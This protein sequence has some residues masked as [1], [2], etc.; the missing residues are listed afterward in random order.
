M[1]KELKV[2]ELF[3]GI[4]AQHKALTNIG[5]NALCTCCDIDKYAIQAYNAIHGET[6]NLGDISAI[7]P[8]QFTKDDYDLITYSSPC[9]TGDTLVM[10]TN[11]YKQIKDI[12]IGDSV[13]T[14]TGTFKKVLNV[15]NNGLKDIIKIK[16]M[17]VDEIKCTSNHK[18][19][20]R[21]K[22]YRWEHKGRLSKEGW[23]KKDKIRYFDEPKWVE[24]KNLSKNHYLGIPINTNEVIPNWN[25]I[26]LEWSDGRKARHKNELSKYMDNNDFWWLIGRYLGDGWCRCDGGII[27]CTAYNEVE[28]V[29]RVLDRIGLHYNK[30]FERTTIKIHIPIKEIG[31]F[32]SQFGKGALNKHLTGI[33]FNLPR[34]LLK[35]FID[36]YLSADGCCCQTEKGEV[37]KASSISRE[38]IYGI[39]ICIMKAYHSPISLYKEKRPSQC[40]IEGRIVNQHSGYQIRFNEY[41]SKSDK[42]FYEGGYIW[43]P[44]NSREDLGKD[45]VYDIEVETDHSFTA[46]NIIVHNC[47]D[48]SF[49][50]LQ[51]GG[52]KGSGTRSSLLWEVEK[53][54]KQVH[55]KYL[56]MENVKALV[57]KKFL[58]CFE[59]WIETLNSYGYKTYWKVL[60]AKNYGI[61]QNRERVFAVSIRNDIDQSFEFP[62]EQ[63]LEKRLKDVLESNVDAKYYLSKQV[64]DRFKFKPKGDNIIGTTMPESRT[65]GQRDVVFG[66]DGL[67]GSLV[68][69]DYKQ[70]KQIIE[71]TNNEPIIVASRGR[72]PNNPND[73]TVGVP[74]EQRLEPNSQGI[75][76]TLTSVQ[77]DNYV[78]EPKIEVLGNY[79]PSGHECGRVMSIDGISPTIKENHGAVCAIA[80][81]QLN[82]IGDVEIKGNDSIKRVYDENGLSPTLTTM[83]GGNCQPK[84][85][86]ND[87]KTMYN[88]YND[89]VISDVAPTQTANCGNSNSSATVL[90]QYNDYRIRKLTPRECYRLMGFSDEDFDKVKSV[91]M[92]DTQCYKQ[93][94]NSIVVNC[95]MAIFTNMF[96]D[97]DYMK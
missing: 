10:T 38:L 34:N 72:N 55:P 70:P 9:F 73:R 79:K 76:N 44:F 84:I 16:C 66:T 96:K 31:L 75:A 12:Q 18:F 6:K 97:T 54:V 21:E 11:G 40:I 61:P 7:D 30:S 53:I 26:D 57:S 41:Q 48:F 36:G 3:S 86:V 19:Y 91:G 71:Y 56:L 77:K 45:I 65:I 80:E 8:N 62:S 68:A 64:Q 89:K 39:S 15:F 24:A 2:L 47:Q 74:T 88:P 17:G 52:E 90:I 14:H 5:I 51:K 28:E 13:I 95:L 43:V 82:H 32:C 94:G 78:L 92:S 50:G 67:M 69:T 42:A 81:P 49:A 37:Y 35:S 25:G 87:I 22:K 93:A 46:N 27:I 58:S 83:G 20:V 63:K 33:I 29:T 23:K 1:T 85:L 4:G 59:K 60:N